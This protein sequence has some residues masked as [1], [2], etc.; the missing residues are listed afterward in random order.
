MRD[1]CAVEI[2]DPTNKAELV[3]QKPGMVLPAGCA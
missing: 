1:E 2:P 3:K